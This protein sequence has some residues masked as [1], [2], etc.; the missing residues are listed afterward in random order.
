MPFAHRQRFQPHSFPCPDGSPRG[1][2]TPDLRLPPESW[3][4]GPLPSEDH[5]LGPWNPLPCESCQI[6]ETPSA[7]VYE[8][9]SE[10]LLTGVGPKKTTRQHILAGLQENFGISMRSRHGK[11][12]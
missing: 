3:L 6:R 11:A 4:Y 1:D 2:A 8:A 10:S 12:E 5:P 9:F 7:G